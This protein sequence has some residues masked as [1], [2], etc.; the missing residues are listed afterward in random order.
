MAGEKPDGGSEP[1]FVFKVLFV[2]LIVALIAA[3]WT[4]ALVFILGFGGIIVA[5]A[6]NNLAAPVAKKLHIPHK[7]AL[8]LTTVALVLAA[9][10]FLAAFGTQAADRFA[11]LAA[12]LP[13]A[14]MATRDWLNSFAGGRWLLPLIDSIP[15]SASENLLSAL[16][17][18]GGVFEIGRAHV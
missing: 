13:Q 1:G 17:L 4:V 18:A 12:Q 10:T 5:T 15:A 14:W 3:I 8:G 16:P 6:L 11:Q 2:A 7:I 9:V